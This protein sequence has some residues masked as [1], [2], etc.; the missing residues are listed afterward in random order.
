MTVAEERLAAMDATVG[1][2]RQIGETQSLETDVVSYGLLPWD[3]SGYWDET[4]T[5]FQT[6]VEGLSHFA[7]AESSVGSGAQAWSVLGWTGDL[8]TVWAGPVA[9]EQRRAH[10]ASLEADIQYRARVIL[11]VTAS[12]QAAA[13]LCA[14]AASPLMAPAA[15]RSLKTLVGELQSF[16]QQVEGSGRPIQSSAVWA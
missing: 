15:F 1:R 16:R 13:S 5:R 14:A 8:A 12:V 2:I 10:F 4:L 9:P 11:I 3:L 6:L 7:A